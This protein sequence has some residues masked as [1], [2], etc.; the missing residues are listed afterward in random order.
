M[1]NIYEMDVFPL[2]FVMI[3]LKSTLFYHFH[4]LHF[5]SQCDCMCRS[6]TWP[7]LT[8]P[9]VISLGVQKNNNKKCNKVT[10]LKV[11]ICRDWV[12]SF[13][14]LGQEGGF[15]SYVYWKKSTFLGIPGW[16]AVI[17][18]EWD[19]FYVDTIKN[20]FCIQNKY[21][22]RSIIIKIFLRCNILWK[23]MLL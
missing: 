23:I 9:Y 5:D 20:Q 11:S 3:W 7:T 22:F 12:D 6:Q 19:S 1:Y 17:F 10:S 21:N 13:N 4:F 18:C 16:R 8:P 14:F 2:C 15:F